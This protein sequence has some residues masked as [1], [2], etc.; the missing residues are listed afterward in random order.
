MING[1]D[2]ITAAQAL[3]GYR[4]AFTD[5]EMGEILAYK[6]VYFSGYKNR[7]IKASSHLPQNCGYD[8]EK[9]DYKIIVRDHIFY[10]YEIVQML[11]KGSF[12]QV[13]KCLDHKT[14]EYVAVKIIRNK[15]RFRA[16]A[17]V[18]VKILVHISENDPDDSSNIIHIIVFNIISFFLIL[19]LIIYK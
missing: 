9:G 5:Y 18:E 3:K 12:G 2:P 10:R 13:L 6:Q 7:K 17:A 19:L 8:D 1:G 11:G 4:D 16:Q 14:N 15:R